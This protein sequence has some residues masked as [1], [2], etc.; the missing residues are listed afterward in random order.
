[1][2][3]LR[4]DEYN[5][6]TPEEVAVAQQKLVSIQGHNT[7]TAIDTLL[8]INGRI[9]QDA[10][11]LVAVSAASPYLFTRFLMREAAQSLSQAISLMSA[12]LE[13]LPIDEGKVNKQGELVLPLSPEEV[14][15]DDRGSGQYV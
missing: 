15:D 2:S 1:M 6:G 12:A 3:D 9:K 4:G 8:E 13:L 10:T 7:E 11:L 14:E 5:L